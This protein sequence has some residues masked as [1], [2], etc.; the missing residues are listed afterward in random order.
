M[1]KFLSICVGAMVAA[2]FCVMFTTKKASTDSPTRL[3]ST[4]DTS[5]IFAVGR[6]EGATP[7]IQL[8][9]Q[10]AGPI[11]QIHVEEGKLV[12]QGQV[13]L[14]IDDRRQRH[15]VAL[16]RADLNLAQAQRQRLVNG[17][18]LEER[19]E[20][21]A[22]YRAR[23]AE[24]EQ[25]R[26]TWQR[27]QPLRQAEAVS[28]QEADNQRSRVDSLTA[29]VGAALA[30]LQL[31]QAP[32]R[33]DDVLIAQARVDAAQ[34]RLELA[35]FELEQTKLR[36]PVSGQVLTI[37]SEVGELAGPTS[38][39]PAIIVAGTGK[40]H[41][42]AFVEE[43]DAP[44]VRNGMAAEIVADGLPNHTFK[45]RVVRLSPRMGRKNMW[46]NKPAERLDTKT[47]E[48]WIQL[49]EA[50]DVVIGLRVDVLI[51]LR[52]PRLVRLTQPLRIENATSPDALTAK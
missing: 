45:G 33:A 37:D 48:V 39:E 24:L 23:V 34:A 51:D 40:F 30:R 26:L 49:D 27:T 46:G 52:A 1:M 20:A 9:P 36:S 44:R 10:A 50:K 6:V 43:M 21:D 12:E 16:A 14:Q 32:A 31:L 3:V 42:R 4:T 2:I 15:A 47:R 18:R 28:Q 41:V 29:E 5:K 25:A 22:L 19:A 7:E 11:T 13:L 8:R 17:A 35:L 38:N